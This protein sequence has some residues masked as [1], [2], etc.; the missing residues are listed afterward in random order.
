MVVVTVELGQDGDP[1][2]R[3][4]STRSLIVV[5]LYIHRQFI[6]IRCIMPAFFVRHRYAM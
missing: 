6:S 4:H 3:V 5:Q 1:L 2:S